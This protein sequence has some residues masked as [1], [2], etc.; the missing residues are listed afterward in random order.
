MEGERKNTHTMGP[1]ES[2]SVSE[3]IFPSLF[4]FAGV[5]SQSLSS[6][7]CSS[8]RAADVRSDDLRTENSVRIFCPGCER[9]H[10]CRFQ[11]REINH[12]ATLLWC[13]FTKG[14]SQVGLCFDYMYEIRGR[15]F[16]FFDPFFLNLRHCVCVCVRKSKNKYDSKNKKSLCDSSLFH[17]AVENTELVYLSRT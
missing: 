8:L 1:T 10:V 11:M 13:L 14:E 3:S 12:V 16:T 4:S 15:I 7:I 5:S 2:S 9:E 17:L 6:S